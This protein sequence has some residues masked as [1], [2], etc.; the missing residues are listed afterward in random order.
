[1][2]TVI[3]L[4]AFL[5]VLFVC[6]WSHAGEFPYAASVSSEKLMARSGPG[7]MFYETNVLSQGSAVTVH[8]HDPGGWYMI[9]PPSDS[10]S[11]I[12][13]DYVTKIT[14]DQGTITD[15][16]VVVRVGST[17]GEYLDVEQRRLNKGDRV[18]IIGEKQ[19]EVSGRAVHFYKVTPPPGEFRWVKGDGL[20]AAASATPERD[21]DPFADVASRSS[22][23]QLGN[24][25]EDAQSSPFDEPSSAQLSSQST[26]QS[27]TQSATAALTN[28]DV[29]SDYQI[30]SML[31]EQFRMMIG[32]D[33]EN[34][35]L[36]DL[37]HDYSKLQQE[38]S[39]EALQHQVD[40]RLAAVERYS[41]KKQAHDQFVQ[42]TTETERRDA[43]LL[44]QH[45]AT[46]TTQQTA[47]QFSNHAMDGIPVGSFEPEISAA[48]NVLPPLPN[49]QTAL[50]ASGIPQ[51]MNPQIPP[52][53]RQ[54]LELSSGTT[55]PVTGG[56]DAHVPEFSGAGIVQMN[57]RPT[58]NL[59][60][61]VLVNPQGQF[62]TF[63]HPAPGVNLASFVGRPAGAV[64][65]R[66]Q[67]PRINADVIVVEKLE[68]IELSPAGQR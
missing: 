44:S 50:S 25:L 14:P 28:A 63:L 43:Q 3:R 51:G 31:D 46:A 4:L 59:P 60:G 52:Q 2:S 26:T 40:L 47:G 34:W 30:L 36:D 57:P 16:N 29:K 56:N 23:V 1:M 27:T 18:A 42:L 24:P 7:S 41:H 38:T 35:K 61:Y 55:M 66:F 10:F 21:A 67:D 53:F 48:G 37:L 9:A 45:N 65:K 8:R 49:E 13:S 39:S 54:G 32:D 11:W 19:F 62:L 12:R 64:G 68:A 15:N 58:P 22:G 6:A 17:V 20:T 33:I 5:S